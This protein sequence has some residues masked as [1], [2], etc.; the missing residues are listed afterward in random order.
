MFIGIYSFLCKLGKHSHIILSLGL[1]HN[2]AVSK[3]TRLMG[4][5]AGENIVQVATYGDFCLA[6]SKDGGVFGW[7]NSEYLQLS[8]V[9]EATQVG[10]G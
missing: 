1:G 7:G 2:S 10:M 4:D 5:I 6:L 8:T 3:P 9:T